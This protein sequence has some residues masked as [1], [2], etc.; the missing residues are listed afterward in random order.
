MLILIMMMMVTITLAGIIRSPNARNAQL[1][2]PRHAIG[3]ADADGADAAAQHLGLGL[4]DE[5]VVGAHEVVP[6]HQHGL[7][8]AGAAREQPVLVQVRRLD[9]LRLHVDQVAPL[10][11]PPHPQRQVR[12]HVDVPQRAPEHRRR[13]VPR[14]EPRVPRPLHVRPV[15]RQRR[16]YGAVEARVRWL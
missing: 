15:R 11:R 6:P 12:V 2:G 1:E 3:Q 4:D 8:L 5:A 9:R 14:P 16:R 7:P 10:V 13:P